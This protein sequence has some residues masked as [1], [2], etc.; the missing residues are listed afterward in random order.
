M[1]SKILLRILQVAFRLGPLLLLST[2]LSATLQAQRIVVLGVPAA[3]MCAFATNPLI[4]DLKGIGFPKD[5]TIA[6]A[7]TP[8]IWERLQ[9]K[10]DDF[11]TVTA[12]TNLKGRLTVL[13][14]TIY[15]EPVPLQ[16]TR[17]WTPRIVLRHELGHILCNCDDEAKADKAASL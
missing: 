1:K 17:H 4:E 15:L 7:C 2:A 13:N 11:N 3:D 8:A 16:G 9:R 6:V 12:F 10:R 5:W 14:G